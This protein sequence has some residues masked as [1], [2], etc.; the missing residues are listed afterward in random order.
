VRASRGS[1]DQSLANGACAGSASPPASIFLCKWSTWKEKE[2]QSK[3]L[4]LLESDARTGVSIQ[5][6]NNKVSP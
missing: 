1:S 4:W 3:K 5:K 2:D 6:Q